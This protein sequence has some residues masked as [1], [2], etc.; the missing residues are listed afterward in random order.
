[1]SQKSIHTH[2]PSHIGFGIIA[3]IVLVLGVILATQYN[4][5]SQTSTGQSMAAGNPPNP[6][7]VTTTCTQWKITYNPKTNQNGETCTHWQTTT[8]TIHTNSPCVEMNTSHQCVQYQTPPSMTTSTCTK[9]TNGSC[10]SKSNSNGKTSTSG[11]GS[12]GETS[13]PCVKNGG[14]CLDTSS[15]TDGNGGWFFSGLCPGSSSNI[16][17]WVP[18]TSVYRPTG[19]VNKNPSKNSISKTH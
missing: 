19:P 3:L 15:R 17:C 6:T 12:N 9:L 1:M 4:T 11:N 16:E 14:T 5:S 7:T 8:V 10:V 2:V 18:P 13:S